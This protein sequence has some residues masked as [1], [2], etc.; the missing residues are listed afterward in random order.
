M[1]GH[2]KKARLT[3]RPMKAA[4]Y[5]FSASQ[6]LLIK[7]RL[8][9][10]RKGLGTSRQVK[11]WSKIAQDIGLLAEQGDLTG[12]EK[13]ILVERYGYY[14]LTQS[15]RGKAPPSDEDIRLGNFSVSD[16]TLQRWFAGKPITG[17]TASVR[18]AYN[19]SLQSIAAIRDFLLIKGY[20]LESE[21]DGA[22]SAFALAFAMNEYA[23]FKPQRHDTPLPAFLPVYHSYSFEQAQLFVRSLSFEVNSEAGYICFST[24]EQSYRVSR[25]GALKDMVARADKL[26]FNTR[27]SMTGWIAQGID[28]SLIAFLDRS[29]FS[30]DPFPIQHISI[31]SAPKNRVRFMDWK[32]LA[33][34]EVRQGQVIKPDM[35]NH[36]THYIEREYPHIFEYFEDKIY[37]GKATSGGDFSRFYQSDGVVLSSEEYSQEDIESGKAVYEEVYKI[38][39]RL[40]GYDYDRPAQLIRAGGGVNYWHPEH[41]CTGFTLGRSSFAASDT[42]CFL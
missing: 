23:G 30:D 36:L 6:K 33:S 12:D 25:Q 21:L 2:M 39:K 28:P 22:H 5:E 17:K 41:G 10:Y 4:L 8:S 42:G 9:R 3:R 27:V 16:D 35:Q 34:C 31:S 26:N 20:L 13:S 14:L 1:M 19:P 29:Q 38:A 15:H 32:P 7:S 18:E 40:P 37:T 11:A 24:D